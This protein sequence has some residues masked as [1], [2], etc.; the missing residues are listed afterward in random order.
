MPS[1]SIEHTAPRERS[2]TTAWYYT[3]TF[4]VIRSYNTV[5]TMDGAWLYRVRCILYELF[6]L[7][8]FEQNPSKDALLGWSS[9]ERLLK[10]NHEISKSTA[11]DKNYT[12][13][14]CVESGLPI[15]PASCCFNRKILQT[16]GCFEYVVVCL[17]I[18]YNEF[19]IV[20]ALPRQLAR[21]EIR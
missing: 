20:E 21:K 6:W 16:L 7:I 1:L 17:H 11:S 18:L 3:S 5:N 2:E 10:I 15:F 9:P 14:E 4:L 19:N 12:A 13:S 8:I